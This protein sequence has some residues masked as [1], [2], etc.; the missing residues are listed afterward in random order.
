[1][2][3][4]IR[5]LTVSDT[6][7]YREIRLE[8]LRCHPEAFSASYDDEAG[9]PDSWFAER[10]GRMALFGG[11]REGSTLLGTAGLLVPESAKLRHAAM[12]VGMYI[13]PDARR[14]GLGLDLVGRVIQE[15]VGLAEEVQ[16]NVTA[17]N[18]AAIRLYR[19]AGFRQC[20]FAARA[21]KVDGVYFDELIMSHSTRC[22]SSG[23]QLSQ[24]P[25]PGSTGAA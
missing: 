2:T 5:P 6:V 15:A 19:R 7:A 17:S 8:A 16:L 9:K 10:I 20:G 3:V 12:L 23:A 14:T 22:S 11:W 1:M 4:T 18:T 25:A 13:R 21:L 24:V